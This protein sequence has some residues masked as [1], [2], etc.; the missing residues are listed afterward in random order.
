MKNLIFFIALISNVSFAQQWQTKEG[1][2]VPDSDAQKSGKYFGAQLVLTNKDEA[3]YA[4]WNIPTEGVH[5]DTSSTV[6]RNES[7]SAFIV[8]GGCK[9][10]AKGNCRL[11]VEFT[12]TQ[13]DAK[14]YSQTTSPM[15]VWYEKKKPPQK[16]L[17]LS[18]DYLKIVFEEGEQVGNYEIVA[19]V[20]DLNANESITL[21][22]GFTAKE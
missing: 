19:K 14:L 12:V 13:P 15:E 4:A 11:V 17:E 21:K 7:I 9:E 22:S 10:N 18:V 16:A 2:P 8:F 3:L 5:I 6:K 1:K 20:S